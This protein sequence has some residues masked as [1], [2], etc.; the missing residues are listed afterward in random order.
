MILYPTMITIGIT[1]TIA[2]GKGAVVEILKEKGFVHYSASGYISEEIKKRGME[3][4]RAHFFVVGNDLRKT[5]GS[6]YIIEEL[7]KRAKVS[8]KNAV[9]EAVRAVGELEF[10]RKQD[11][12]YLIAVDADPKIRYERG[13]KRNR[14]LDHVSFETFLENEKN[15]MKSIN[16]HEMNLTYCIDHADFKIMN[17]STK[18]ELRTQVE[19]ILKEIAPM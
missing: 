2:S 18:G 13:V 3:L 9:I 5:Y 7:Y 17:D 4:T 8:G 11:N 10:L 14:S 6:S 16:P 1:G 19:E 12:F 15:E